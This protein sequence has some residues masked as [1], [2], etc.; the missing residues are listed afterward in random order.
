MWKLL[1]LSLKD[2]CALGA[3]P[4]EKNLCLAKLPGRQLLECLLALHAS[5]K[6]QISTCHT[7]IQQG[8]AESNPVSV[9]SLLVMTDG[10]LSALM[11]E[12]VKRWCGNHVRVLSSLLISKKS[13]LSFTFFTYKTG[14][15]KA[16]DTEDTNCH[17]H[18]Q[19][20][21]TCDKRHLL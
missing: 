12:K 4:T 2:H 6:F 13:H 20:K 1:S 21:S 19:K 5:F 7:K 11:E 8:L 9:S 15:L 17:D 3:S 14:K 16:I 18:Q 10:N